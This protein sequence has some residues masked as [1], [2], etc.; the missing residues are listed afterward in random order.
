M[1]RGRFFVVLLLPIALGG[2]ED[3]YAHL[4]EVKASLE[5]EF[6]H[7]HVPV[8]PL[9]GY[10][11]NEAD[12]L[13]MPNDLLVLGDYVVAADYPGYAL[14][15]VS[16]ADGRLVRSSGALGEGPGEYLG[17]PDLLHDPNDPSVFWSYDASQSRLARYEIDRWID[18]PDFEPR[19]RVLKL[20]YLLY[21]LSFI[22]DDRLFGLGLFPDNRLALIDSTSITYAGEL[23]RRPDQRD[24]PGPVLQ[25]AHH[26]TFGSGPS[27]KPIVIAS[28]RSS[29]IELYEPDGQL[30][31]SFHGPFSFEP[32]FSVVVNGS[33]P[34]FEAGLRHRYGYLDVVGTEDGFLALFSGR[35]DAHYPSES[36]LGEYVHMFDWDGRFLEAYHLDRPAVAIELDRAARRL[37]ITTIEPYPSIRVYNLPSPKSS[38]AAAADGSASASDNR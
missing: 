11:L 30:L 25:R 24:V 27:G 26:G 9:S 6:S 4:A 34:G 5:P 15:V 23:P 28:R 31:R 21:A 33:T 8:T 14:H 20:D 37:I 12:I 35:A 2:C 13:A 3:R 17:P 7:T 22:G 16:L 36:W 38:I 18:D 19:H 32:D 1:T 29:R 10:A